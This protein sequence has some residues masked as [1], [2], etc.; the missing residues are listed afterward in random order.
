MHFVH[1]SDI[2]VIYFSNFEW[3]SSIYSY[4]T[5]Q[6]EYSMTENTFPSLPFRLKKN[7]FIYIIITYF[8]GQENY[9]N[10]MSLLDYPA[11]FVKWAFFFI[12]GDR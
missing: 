1:Q 10:S 7:V 11:N 8:P 2:S 6:I 5:I 9:N 12:L 4:L 3:I